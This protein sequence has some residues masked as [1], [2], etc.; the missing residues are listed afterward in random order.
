MLLLAEALSGRWFGGALRYWMILSEF[1][2]S[3]G[4]GIATYG[5]EITAA[6]RQSGHDVTVFIPG[7]PDQSEVFASIRPDGIKVV[8]VGLTR[9][10]MLDHALSWWQLFSHRTCAHLVEL[11]AAGERPDVI[12][13]QDYGAPGYYLLKHRLLNGGTLGDI[14]VVMF[15]HSPMFEIAVADEVPAY[16]FPTYGVGRTEKFCLMA[17]DK[18]ICPSQF[19][20]TRLARYR[21]DEIAVVPL[22]YAIAGSGPIA[23]PNAPPYDLLYL[24]KTQYLKG[25]VHLL[26]GMEVLWREGSEARLRVVGADTVWQS[27]ETSMKEYI[28]RHYAAQLESRLLVLDEA[29]G[30]HELATTYASARIALVPSLFDNFPYACVEAMAHGVPVLGSRTGGQAEMLAAADQQTHL[31]D[32]DNPRDVADVVGR[33]LSHAPTQISAAGTAGR[34]AIAELCR[35]ARVVAL[36]E[37]ILATFSRTGLRSPTRT[38]P[39]V[40]DVERMER[41]GVP[42]SSPSAIR[43]TDGAALLSVVV[44]HF[45]LSATIEETIAS[46]MASDYPAI[47]VIVIDDGSTEVAA[48]KM[49]GRIEA[50]AHRLPL[51]IERIANGGLANAR[52]MGARLARGEYLAFLDADDVVRPTYYARAIDLLSRFENVS[53]AYSWLEYF[54]GSIGYWITFDT[55]LPYLLGS[56]MTCATLVIRTKDYLA[57]GLNAPIMKYGMED[58]EAWISLAAAGKLGVAIPEFLTRYRLR[59]GSMSRQFTPST[60]TW[61]YE[62][63][64]EL[65]C[66]TF[67]EWGDELA[68]LTYANGP[69]RLW[70]NFTV[71]QGEVGFVEGG[72]GYNFRVL[73]T[74]FTPSQ[75]QELVGLLNDPTARRVARAVLGTRLH[76]PILAAFRFWARLA[77]QRR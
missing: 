69:G 75:Q 43:A 66:G 25:I 62:R 7:E 5:R 46:I 49:L 13:V 33:T 68:Q 48:T 28:R 34:V 22:P 60:V 37:E 14:P 23:Q 12:E 32:I 30:Q 38:Y 73:S 36:R 64:V 67:E 35:P 53:Y 29:I 4:G 20:A 45:N 21:A 24:G 57:H 56:N 3:F 59:A 61:L 52:N 8:Y 6:L 71:G 2:P 17:V 76:T 50:T 44:P 63:L 41:R 19:L 15:C 55:D 1:P 11:I 9:G 26:R 39:F 31:F 54:G 51:R 72:A 27:R 42:L 10:D 40:N 16:K 18:V 70:N 65:N 47:E 74:S 77:R 58:Y